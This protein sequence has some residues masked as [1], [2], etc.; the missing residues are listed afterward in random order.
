MIINFFVEYLYLV[1][2]PVDRFP[3]SAVVGTRPTGR[4]I[5]SSNPGSAVGFFL[6]H[7]LFDTILKIYVIFRYFIRDRESL[8]DEITEENNVFASITRIMLITDSQQSVSARLE[9]DDQPGILENIHV[10][11]KSPF[12]SNA[13]DSSLNCARPL[14]DTQAG[15]RRCAVELRRSGTRNDVRKSRAFNIECTLISQY[16]RYLAKYRRYL[17]NVGL[18]TVAFTMSDSSIIVKVPKSLREWSSV[19]RAHPPRSS[20][21]LRRLWRALRLIENEQM[22]YAYKINNPIHFF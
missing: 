22:Q 9:R 3:Y 4:N 18:M 21:D 13:S 15:W 16:L 8:I 11:E 17:K 19:R 12:R 2:C 10:L 6:F 7:I 1:N 14:V 20:Y 5:A